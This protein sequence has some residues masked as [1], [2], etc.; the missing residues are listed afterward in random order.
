[1]QIT[2]G[3]S[4]DD[5]LATLVVVEAKKRT[6]AES[7]QKEFVRKH[8]ELT[9]EFTLANSETSKRNY[10]LQRH[11]EFD[12]HVCEHEPAGPFLCS[13]FG[14]EQGQKLVH[15]VIFPLSQHGVM[16]QEMMKEAKK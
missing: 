7:A 8:T 14:P 15:N 16:G 10:V 9:N 1:M 4:L 6:A 13:V 11:S 3:K 2:R 12:T 5:Q